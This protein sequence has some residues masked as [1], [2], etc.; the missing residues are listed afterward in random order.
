MK[1]LKHPP[2]WEG[3]DTVNTPP[4]FKK[5]KSEDELEDAEDLQEDDYEDDDDA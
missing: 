4:G 1:P 3:N 2:A 5:V